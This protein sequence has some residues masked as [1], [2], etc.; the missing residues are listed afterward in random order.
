MDS[1]QLK[2]WQAEKI[3][4]ALGP[5]L[6]YV[7]LLKTRM[8]RVG[9]LPDDPLYRLVKQ[10]YESLHRLSVE[11]HYRSCSGGVGQEPHGESHDRS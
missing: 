1:R 7:G 8:E 3:H 9:F 2:R 10:T 11:M 6:R 5:G 4:K